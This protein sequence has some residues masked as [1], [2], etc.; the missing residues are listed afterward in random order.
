MALG[1]SETVGKVSARLPCPICVVQNCVLLGIRK[2]GGLGWSSICIRRVLV[3][4]WLVQ[5]CKLRYGVR[6]TT[7]I[8]PDERKT[9][10]EGGSTC[11]FFFFPH[12]VSTRIFLAT[13]RRKREKGMYRLFLSIPCYFIFIFFRG[14]K[15]LATF[16]SR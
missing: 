2:E 4:S 9:F 3:V 8:S 16:T 11:S 5:V 6:G 12:R 7:F 13:L 1:G 14:R 10:E 15:V